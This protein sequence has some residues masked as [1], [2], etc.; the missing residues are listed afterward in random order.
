MIRQGPTRISVGTVLWNILYDEVLRMEMSGGC[1][2]MTYADSLDLIAVNP[3]IESPKS[4]VELTITRDLQTADL[5]GRRKH[6]RIFSYIILT[7]WA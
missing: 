1:E 3:G 5:A 6:L 4:K 7:L 2:L